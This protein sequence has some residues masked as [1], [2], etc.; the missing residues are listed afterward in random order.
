MKVS[1][2]GAFRT[3]TAGQLSALRDHLQRL[4]QQ[5]RYDRFNGFVDSAFI[6][7]Y[8]AR[9]TGDGTVVFAYPEDGVIRGAAELHRPD[10]DD[11]ASLPEVAFSVEASWRGMG[12]GTTLFKRLI[13]GAR[14][15]GYKHLRITTGAQNDAMR[16]LAHKFDAHLSFRQGESTGTIDLDSAQ[17]MSIVPEAQPAADALN[18]MV[19]MNRSWWSTILAMYGLGRPV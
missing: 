6:D 5:S 16:A 17:V 19:G 2:E 11:A 18:A 8:V 4:D 14:R 7:R 12:I 1:A 9:C 3:L 15:L 13:E 10:S